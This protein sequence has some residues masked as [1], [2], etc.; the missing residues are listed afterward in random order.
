MT[1]EV[2]SL[3][4]EQ[5]AAWFSQ[6]PSFSLM[7][8]YSSGKSALL[9]C[10][11]GQQ[12]LPTRVTATDL[13][14]VWITEGKALRLRGLSHDGRL[15]DL[16]LDDL[17]SAQAMQF[18]VIRIEAKADILRR[19]DIIDTPGISDPRMS[20]AIV[21]EIAKY[22]DFTVWCSPLN[23]AWRQTERAFWRGLPN[24]LKPLSVLALTRADMLRGQGDI[25]KVTRRCKAETGT[26][27]AAVLPVSAPLAIAAQ[28]LPPGP[29]RDSMLTRS[30]VEPLLDRISLSVSDS[31]TLCAAR[32]KL[33]QPG[34]KVNQ[35]IATKGRKSPDKIRVEKQE[36]QPKIVS[37]G[38]TTAKLVS[39]LMTLRSEVKDFS[40]NEHIL[41]TI[42]HHFSQ[43]TNDNTLT[44]EHRDV[45][46]RAL[47]VR[48]G[49]TKDPARYLKQVEDEV[50]DFADGP[51]CELG[52]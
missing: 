11:L 39:D 3:A 44:A 14:A 49:N 32:P 12:L 48:D 25:D 47:T 21:E 41:A 4:S 40:R 9:N 18:L 52:R 15:E 16:T 29:E 1:E 38:E 30:G 28:E 6:K 2:S 19:T 7:G 34:E 8:E 24:R 10:L 42:S 13:P 27:F 35:A 43:L 45:L 31:E 37:A 46:A 20:T 50:E 5:M 51:W 22:S 26:E 17:Q 36:K 23:Q 33:N